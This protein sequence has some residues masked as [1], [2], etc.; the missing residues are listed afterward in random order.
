[1]VNND[2]KEEEVLYERRGSRC[3]FKRWFP[4]KNYEIQLRLDY[5]GK[6]NEAPILDA[7]IRDTTTGKLV[8]RDLWHHTE[9]KHD[10]ASNTDSYIFKFDSLVL[11]FC[12]ITT[13][14]LDQ[15]F[16]VAVGKR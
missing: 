8:K 5:N 11:R 10:A 9:V 2:T 1:M 15:S 14:A 4:Y 3:R 12:I 6:P 13:A 7:D 16:R